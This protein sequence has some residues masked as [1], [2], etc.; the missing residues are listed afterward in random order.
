MKFAIRN[1]NVCA[2]LAAALWLPAAASAATYHVATTG[3][4]AN[5]DGSAASPFASVDHALGLTACGGIVKVAGGT[6]TVTARGLSEEK[7][8]IRGVKLNG[9]PYDL[10]YI[11]YKDIVA[12]G[13]LE[14]TMGK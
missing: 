13:K 8:Y 4:D 12:G 10:P 3:S 11:D 5:G 7:P 14:F 9:K 1:P 6:F 2:A